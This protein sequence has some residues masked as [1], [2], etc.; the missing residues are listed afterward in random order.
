MSAQSAIITL[1]S[2][3]MALAIL[4]PAKDTAGSAAETVDDW[5]NTVKGII[6]TAS[7]AKSL[8]TGD[9][10]DDESDDES[11][12]DGDGDGDGGDGYV[13]YSEEHLEDIWSICHSSTRAIRQFCRKGSCGGCEWARST[14]ACHSFANASFPLFRNACRKDFAKCGRF[15]A[16]AIKFCNGKCTVE[17]DT[18]DC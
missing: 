3:L 14:K 4:M 10:S 12:G 13:N 2:A 17:D 1:A 18:I 5:A 8:I 16:N 11:D 6:G 7:A 9:D 15:I